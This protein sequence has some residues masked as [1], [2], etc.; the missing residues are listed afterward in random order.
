[1]AQVRYSDLHGEENSGSRI[2]T[3]FSKGI[4]TRATSSNPRHSFTPP[5]PPVYPSYTHY[6]PSSSEQAETR[7]TRLDRHLPRALSLDGPL[8]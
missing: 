3:G 8:P 1:M 4:C 6:P 5:H 7:P 2:K